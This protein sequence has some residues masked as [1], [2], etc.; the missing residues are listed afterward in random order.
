MCGVMSRGRRGS[1]MDLQTI[2]SSASGMFAE[3]LGR[4]LRVLKVT[5]D[6]AC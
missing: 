5:R 4:R 3:L 6:V 2:C 1:E